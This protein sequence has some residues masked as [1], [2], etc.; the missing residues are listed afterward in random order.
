MERKKDYIFAMQANIKNNSTDLQN[1]VNDLD[2]W[3]KEIE[4]KD[5]DSKLRDPNKN[6]SRTF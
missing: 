5:K 1:F 3:T 2:D 6:V 4:P